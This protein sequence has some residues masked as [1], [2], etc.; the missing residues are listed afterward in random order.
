MQTVNF[1]IIVW[2]FNYSYL[3]IK[4]CHERKQFASIGG[5]SH[6]VVT[7]SIRT[8]GSYSASLT[9]L[10]TAQFNEAYH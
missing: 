7:L 6:F 2:L 4:I 3:N 8:N 9:V 1:F 5:V 10:D